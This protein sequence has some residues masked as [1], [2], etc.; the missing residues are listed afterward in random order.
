MQPTG[1]L[2]FIILCILTF[3]SSIV[4]RNVYETCT[5]RVHSRLELIPIPN[6][7]V[8]ITLYRNA[9]VLDLAPLDEKRIQLVLDTQRLAALQ[10]TLSLQQSTRLQP[11]TQ[12]SPL[13]WQQQESTR[14]PHYQDEKPQ[15]QQQ[16]PPQ[17]QVGQEQSNHEHQPPSHTPSITTTETPRTNSTDVIQKR[18]RRSNPLGFKRSRK[19]KRP[20]H[21]LAVDQTQTKPLLHLQ[22]AKIEPS[23]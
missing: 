23:A 19:A 1:L 5:K 16:Q 14:P 2:A 20:R 22:R 7:L 6:V 3:F 10:Q 9:Y 11:D 18:K 8:R 13:T 15:Q 12:V 17:L 21:E 4:F